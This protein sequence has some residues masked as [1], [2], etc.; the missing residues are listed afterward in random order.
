MKIAIVNSQGYNKSV[1]DHTVGNELNSLLNCDGVFFDSPL[2]NDGSIKDIPLV[3]TSVGIQNLIL[4]EE[5]RVKA[6]ESIGIT[7]GKAKGARDTCLYSLFNGK[8]FAEFM[9]ISYSDRFMTGDVGPEVG[10]SHG[11]G[12][13][14]GTQIYEA[15]PSLIRL[16]E[17]LTKLD[18]HGEILLNVTPEYLVTNVWFGHCEWAFPL[19]S[20][21]S[22]NNVQ[23][24]L[25]FMF[26][27]SIEIKLYDSI[28]ISTLVS[29]PP[30]PTIGLSNKII[31][32][33][34]G[35]EK[36]LWRFQTLGSEQLCI[37]CHGAYLREARKRI[38]RTL[39]NLV[40]FD[41]SLQYRIDYGLRMP[42][43]FMADKYKEF[44]AG[45]FTPQQPSPSSS[46]IP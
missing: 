9:E 27:K 20:E 18:Y 32:A 17:M 12:I 15:F 10:F 31:H 24:L 4:N 44:E 25:L 19:Y 33:P 3:N 14:C 40:Q 41:S 13:K 21:I 26:G 39:D 6:F 16:R 46:H 22:Q 8:E 36:H 2:I 38:R 45:E 28:A 35:A 29:L 11:V 34:K 7:L 30:F 23:D 5:L 43:T 42:F 37:V 1:W